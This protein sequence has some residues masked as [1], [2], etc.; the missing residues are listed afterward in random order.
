[1]FYLQMIELHPES[2]VFWY[3]GHKNAAL[4]STKTAG[5]LTAFLMDTF[6]T[7][8]ILAISNL[9]GGGTKGYKPLN[10]VI[11]SAMRGKICS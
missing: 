9:K 10:S 6:F 1:M 7:K 4:S 5:E 3:T 11:I 8:E 2:G